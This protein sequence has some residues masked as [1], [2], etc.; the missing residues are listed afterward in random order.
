[1]SNETLLIDLHLLEPGAQYE[2]AVR[3]AGHSIGCTLGVD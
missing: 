3:G 2:L 1:M